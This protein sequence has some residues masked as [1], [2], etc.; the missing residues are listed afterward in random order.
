MSIF[1][2]VVSYRDPEIVPT[3]KSLVDNADNPDSLHLGIVTQDVNNRHPSFDHDSI[4]HLKVHAG[5][6]K[7]VG[8]AR[9]LAMSLYQGEDF[10]FQIDSHMRFAK[11]WDTKLVEMYKWCAEDA[12]TN[13]IILS[14]FPAAYIVGS[15]GKDYLLENDE[16]WAEPS[17]TK[18]R[19]NEDGTWGGQRVRMED[20]ST[21]QKSHTVLAGYLFAHGDIV[22]EVPYDERISFMGE[23]IC[24]ALR[25]YTRGWEIYAPN[26]MLA[27]HFYE[28][29]NSR[30]IWNDGVRK[31]TWFDMEKESR[32]VQRSVLLAEDNG[33]F[34]IDDFGRYFDFQDNN[35]VDFELFYNSNELAKKE[36]LSIIVEELDFFSPVRTGYCINELH[37]ECNGKGCHCECHKEN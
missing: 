3:I 2:S 34:G 22:N 21:P 16:Y 6:A 4:Q 5:D 31:R 8:Y 36:N 18:V 24:L 26:E 13:K 12:G 19:V 32:E 27:W 28:R 1:V 17:T 9:K 15:D 10:Y 30:K 29:R 33:I 25:A 7:G 11:G 35:G 37:D 23:E 20:M 14:Q